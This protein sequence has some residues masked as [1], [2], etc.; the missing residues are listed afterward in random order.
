[1]HR[2]N[3]NRRIT[4]KLRRGLTLLE[5][6][7]VLVI[8]TTLGTVMLTQT[9]S[10]TGQA[11]YDQS[12]RNLEIIREAVIGRQP[13]TGEDPTA[14]PP[15]FVADVGRLPQAGPGLDLSELWNREAT[16]I[17][18]T[19]FSVQAL[20]GLDDDLHIACGWRGPYVRLPAGSDDLRDGWGRPFD[21]WH[22]DESAVSDASDVIAA[23][24]SAGSG[25][26]DSFDIPLDQV[27]FADSAGDQTTGS[28]TLQLQLTLPA[29][30]T[31]THA[32]VRLYG[33]VNGTAAVVA[34]SEALPGTAG[35]T[36]TVTVTFTPSNIPI[37]PKILRAYGWSS[38]VSP[39][40][41]ADLTGRAKSSAR[42]VTVLPGGA[43]W[44]DLTLV[45]E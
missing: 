38:G 39:A 23:V 19:L 8:L 35:M 22:S 2:F 4:M 29:P 14:V 30:A 31:D 11:R 37:G 25:A 40:T 12:V 1:M 18:P 13:A 5:L 34:Q 21:L 20:T 42:R 41:T 3:L 9:A 7:V 10:L 33:P 27:I 44:P 24:S 15:G 45:G 6:I 16:K 26:A 17:P 28:I 36:Q 43:T 32:I